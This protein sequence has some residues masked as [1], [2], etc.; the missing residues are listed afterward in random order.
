MIHL[1]CTSDIHGNVLNYDVALDQ[2]KPYGLSSL[3]SL[4]QRF[5]PLNTL[6]IDNGDALQGSALTTYLHTQPQAK[7]SIAQAMNLLGYHYFNLGNH[8]FNYGLDV[9]FSFLQ[10]L[11]APCITGNVLYQGKPLGES[12]IHTLNNHTLGLIGAVTDYIPNWEKPEHLHDI[13]FIDVLTHVKNEV[14]RLRPY[15]DHIIVVYHGGFEKDIHTGEPTERLTKENVGYELSLIEGIDVLFTGHQHRSIATHTRDKALLQCG[16]EGI[17]VMHAHLEHQQWTPNLIE[18]KA[19]EKTTILEEWF[20]DGVEAF[21]SWLNTPVGALDEDRYQLTTDL[22][23]RLHK[24]ALV[25][26]FNHVMRQKTK[27]QLA[28]SSLFNALVGLPQYPTMK[29]LLAAYPYPNIIVVKELSA[30]T[31]KAYLEQNASFFSLDE[32]QN[33]IITPSFV[34]PK[35]QLYN[36]DMVDGIDYVIDV[37][38]PIGQRVISMQY[39]GQAIT[40]NQVF[41]CAMNNYRSVGGGDFDM[42]AKAPLLLD[43][44]KD[45]MTLLQEFLTSTKRVVVPHT[46]NITLLKGD[47]P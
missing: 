24:P 10:A 25:S 40:S 23:S 8:D 36:Y 32:A 42:I 1:L 43:T 38:Q 28:S 7:H 31:L 19:F 41:S 15:V 27:A 5:D 6:L 45:M 16:F 34:F 35:K 2:S 39:Q 44:G 9:L 30:S 14:E 29:D 22:E 26:L 17:E 11:D 21:N 20:K 47:Q 37:S 12:K 3:P 4:L 46:E 13:T 33:I 18:L